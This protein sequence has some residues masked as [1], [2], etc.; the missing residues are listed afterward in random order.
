M[1]LKYF[2]TVG[3]RIERSI[4]K[5]KKYFDVVA[6]CRKDRITVPITP[7]LKP[8]ATRKQLNMIPHRFHVDLPEDLIIAIVKCKDNKQMIWFLI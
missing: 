4:L 1:S 7:V 2:G 3:L 6:K 5:S 8:I